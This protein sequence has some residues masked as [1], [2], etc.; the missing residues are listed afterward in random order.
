MSLKSYG[1]GWKSGQGLQVVIS[2]RCCWTA[3]RSNPPSSC[4]DNESMGPDCDA[5]LLEVCTGSHFCQ[6]RCQLVP[7]ACSSQTQVCPCVHLCSGGQCPRWVALIMLHAW[8]LPLPAAPHAA[9]CGRPGAIWACS[10][11]SVGTTEGSPSMSRL[12]G[13][14]STLR[15][16]GGVVHASPSMS[17]G[18][19]R[20][21]CAARRPGRAANAGG[22]GSSSTCRRLRRSADHC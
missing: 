5:D 13:R 18:C 20:A 7:V 12:S 3:S 22:C 6:G 8:R 2:L 16:P 17:G 21:V 4:R 10:A 11:P 9:A 15:R 1:Q 19:Q 14:C